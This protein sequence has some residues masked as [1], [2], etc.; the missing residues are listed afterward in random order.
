M[1]YG[2]FN[3]SLDCI[4]EL[5]SSVWSSEKLDVH[6]IEHCM[7]LK[8]LPSN[9]CKLKCSSDFTL[10]GCSSLVNFTE[11]PSNMTRLDLSGSA[12][13]VLPSSIERLFSLTSIELKNCKRLVTPSDNL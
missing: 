11:L 9:S 13:E 10:Q 4:E 2:N 8:N 3:V 5:P 12:I 6:H 7:H 1:Q